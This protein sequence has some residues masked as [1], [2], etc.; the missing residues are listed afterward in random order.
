MS[1]AADGVQRHELA[2][3]HPRLHQLAQVAPL[4]TDVHR[5]VEALEGGAGAY[6]QGAVGG[7][8]IVAMI[9]NIGSNST[10]C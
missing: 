10:A 4:E 3:F 1:G 9:I 8:L 6:L 5:G 2:A 7:E